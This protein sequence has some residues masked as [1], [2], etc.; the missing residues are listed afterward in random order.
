M[1][2]GIQAVFFEKTH[3][4]NY[5]R[6]GYKLSLRWKEQRWLAEIV[7][8]S[9]ALP[10]FRVRLTTIPGPIGSFLIIVC[11]HAHYFDRFHFIRNFID[12]PMLY[13]N[14]SGISAFQITEQLL[15]RRRFWEGFSSNILITLSVWDRNS[16]AEIFFASF[17]ACFVYT[18]FEITSEGPLNIFRPV[19]SSPC[20][21]TLP[22][23]E[24]KAGKAF[25]ESNSN[26]FQKPLLPYPFFGNMHCLVWLV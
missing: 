16:E 7:F 2:E 20:S 4:R 11:P 13:S 5:N 15:N 10:L 1:R 26:R 21:L 17:W 12:K 25:P 19:F 22:C 14:A 9:Q 24:L 8:S 18:I 6:S 3:H 23:L